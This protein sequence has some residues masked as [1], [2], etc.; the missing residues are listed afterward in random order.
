MAT[1][2]YERLTTKPA[3]APRSCG[4]PQCPAQRQARK[5]A[6]H[7]YTGREWSAEDSQPITARVDDVMH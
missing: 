1:D 7:R 2:S 4:F 6:E 3:R 5:Y